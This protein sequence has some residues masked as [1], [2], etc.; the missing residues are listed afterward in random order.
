MSAFLAA[1]GLHLRI[2]AVTPLAV[3]MSVLQPVAL[4]LIVV[5]ADG[6]PTM[7]A[8]AGTGIAAMVGTASTQTVVA[9][10]Q[11]RGWLTLEQTM[12][13][14]VNTGLVLAGRTAAAV[15][16]AAVALPIA[17]VAIVVAFGSF[18]VSSP[19]QL[20]ACASVA[21]GGAT[22]LCLMV[23]GFTARHRYRPG[24]ANVVF[25][26]LSLVAGVFVPVSTLPGW[27]EPVSRLFA[28]TWAMEGIRAVQTGGSAWSDIGVGALI[29][30]AS[31]AGGLVYLAGLDERMRAGSETHL[32]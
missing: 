31:L 12:L 2:E 8:A 30:V 3:V 9:T 10:L 5:A 18:R 20:A 6:Q 29:A 32:R 21:A 4:G 11:E 26:V 17:W 22:A 24:V 1:A 7:A 19:L 27:I 13:S 23:M 14:P 25:P 16:Q 15:L 28:I